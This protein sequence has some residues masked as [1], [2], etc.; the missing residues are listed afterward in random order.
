M[1]TGRCSHVMSNKLVQHKKAQRRILCVVQSLHAKLRLLLA[2]KVG[3]GPHC[4][5]SRKVI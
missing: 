5:L 3:W 4:M 2:G 1:N